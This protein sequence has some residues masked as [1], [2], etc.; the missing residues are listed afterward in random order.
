LRIITFAR[1]IFAPFFPKKRAKPERFPFYFQKSALN[2]NGSVFIFKTSCRVVS[3][4]R[5]DMTQMTG[6][7]AAVSSAGRRRSPGGAGA[8][9]TH[10]A[11]SRPGRAEIPNLNQN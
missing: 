1:K 3:S 6:T 9:L 11:A 10:S 7:A 5:H 4:M 2:R 8:P